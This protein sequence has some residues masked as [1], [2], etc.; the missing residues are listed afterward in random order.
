MSKGGAKSIGSNA[1]PRVQ[2]AYKTDDDGAQEEVS[3]PFIMA[4]M[5]DFAGKTGQADIEE[6]CQ[7]SDGYCHAQ[8]TMNSS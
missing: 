5:G 3:L 6:Q 8:L 1:P 4:V 7:F 2:I